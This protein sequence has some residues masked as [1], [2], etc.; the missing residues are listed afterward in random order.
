MQAVAVPV[1]EPVAAGKVQPGMVAQEEE[2]K[3]AQDVVLGVPVQR[4]PSE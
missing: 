2:E 1:Q 3:L 4:M